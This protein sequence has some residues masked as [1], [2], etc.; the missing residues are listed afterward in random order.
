[1]PGTSDG[2]LNYGDSRTASVLRGFMAIP[3]LAFSLSM[4]FSGAVS[5]F[6]LA[7]YKDKLFQYP[8]VLEQSH[9]GAFVRVEYTKKR[10]LYG[11]DEVREIRAHRRYV[12][13]KPRRKQKKLVLSV[14]DRKIDY[15]G[16]GKLGGGA[17]A[18]VIYVHGKGGN[19][20]QGAN[21]W[22]FGGNFNRVRNLMLRN[23]GIYISTDITDFGRKGVED[24]MALMRTYRKTSPKAPVFIACGSMGGHICWSLMRSNE[25]ASMLGGVLLL[26]SLVD[27]GFLSS[28]M[29]SGSG[30]AV[31]IY[32]GQG[33]ED[34]V[35][36]WQGQQ[37]FFTSL[38]AR[39]PDYPIR[40]T[41]FDSGSHGTPI[42]MTDWRLILN[43]ML[44]GR[45]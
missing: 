34:P 23:G 24:V 31:P 17:K 27:K 37:A 43:W 5:A 42:R 18:I 33:S 28:A 4:G 22:S 15:I 12:S 9:K 39:R 38:K 36:N 41:L 10:D 7:P 2:K 30:R 26:G 19:R 45:S 13:L 35:F 1:M 14:T 6:E 44:S 20:L 16:L 40:F 3:M 25:A 11:R 21:D 8:K 32:L 29:A